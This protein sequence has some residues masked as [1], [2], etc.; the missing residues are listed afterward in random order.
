ML[1]EIHYNPGNTLYEH[2]Y[3]PHRIISNYVSRSVSEI[4]LY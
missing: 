1:A 2:N 4:K 3:I